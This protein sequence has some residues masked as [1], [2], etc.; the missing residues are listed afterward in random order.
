MTQ[1]VQNKK[2]TQKIAINTYYS[3][4]IGIKY[5]QI[6]IVTEEIK[7]HICIY[8]WDLYFLCRLNVCPY[9]RPVCIKNTT[10]F[11]II[12]GPTLSPVT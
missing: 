7:K 10:Y 11:L 6:L 3:Q 4:G 9:Y 2:S 8:D 1:V 12:S 5:N